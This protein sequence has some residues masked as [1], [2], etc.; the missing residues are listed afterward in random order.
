MAKNKHPQVVCLVGSFDPNYLGHTPLFKEAKKL[1]DKLIVLI[2]SNAWLENNRGF[3]FLGEKHRKEMIESIEYVDQVIITHHEEDSQDQ[4]VA[5]DLKRI[6]PDV[7]AKLNSAS[8]REKEVCQKK[9]CEIV[10][11]KV[12]SIFP[13]NLW[14]L[15]KYF[16]KL[17]SFN[18]REEETSTFDKAEVNPIISPSE[19][20]WESKATFNAAAIEQ[21]EEM[22]VLYRAIGEDNR[23]VLG[24]AV[25]E[26]G[27]SI[28]YKSEEPAYDPGRIKD[29]LEKK[30]MSDL[31]S[32]NSGGGWRGGAE[33]PRLAAVGSKIY[34]TYTS[35]DGVHLPHVSMTYIDK[36]DFLNE[37]WDW[38]EPIRLSPQG[39]INKNWVVFP[40]KVN[41][42]FAVLHSLSPEISISYFD[43]LE[44]E[45]NYPINSYY[46]GAVMGR[47]DY[48]DSWVRGAGPP[49]IKTEQGWLLFYHG[50]EEKGARK[51]KIGAFLLDLEDP[52]KILARS[53]EPLIEPE[54]E[55]E[56]EKGMKP[57]VVYTCG[58]GILGDELYLYYGGA[59]T[60][61]CA[62]SAKVNKLLEKIK[63]DKTNLKYA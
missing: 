43:D 59:D 37:K 46:D 32:Y 53:P 31:S 17:F 5:K 11:F 56:N 23:S 41:G 18:R 8:I 28:D 62:A 45:S 20:D 54:E 14:L 1:G 47:D 21:N 7:F 26:D 40:G 55:Y 10:N 61:L 2:R 35:F 9:D 13:S 4:S 42:K 15:L 44:D 27:T 63:Q 25:S 36:E 57:G 38:S 48:W 3:L 52:G 50:M 58:A 19:K 33:D 49:P 22:H 39:E 24:H 60:F 30:K 12:S 34:M 29:K 6:D 51:Y 16:S